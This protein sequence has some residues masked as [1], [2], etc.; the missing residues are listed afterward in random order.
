MNAFHLI[1]LYFLSGSF[2]VMFSVLCCGC[3]ILLL[4]LQLWIGSL[5]MTRKW[6]D[7]KM[8]K[9]AIYRC[10]EVAV[11]DPNEIAVPDC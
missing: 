6:L 2:K 7:V 4:V 1:G 3:V 11:L 5:D 8:H 10:V 9:I